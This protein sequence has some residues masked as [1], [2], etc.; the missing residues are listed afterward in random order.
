M[1][2]MAKKRSKWYWLKENQIF[3]ILGSAIG[4]AVLF[5]SL[6][7]YQFQKSQKKSPNLDLKLEK[8]NVP[9]KEICLLLKNSGDASANQVKVKIYMPKNIGDWRC[10]ATLVEPIKES[11]TL[12]IVDYGRKTIDPL[13]EIVTRYYIEII[14]INSEELRKSNK[15]LRYRIECKEADPVGKIISI[16]DIFMAKPYLWGE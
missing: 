4:I 12:I 10:K 8:V 15:P 14:D 1:K 5:I 6:C 7:S 9:G 11:D 2:Y 3:T 13:D 16:N